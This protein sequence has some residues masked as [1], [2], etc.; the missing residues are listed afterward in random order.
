MSVCLLSVCPSFLSSLTYSIFTRASLLHCL[1]RTGILAVVIS[2]LFVYVLFGSPRE[3]PADDALL[4]AEVAIECLRARQ[5]VLIN[6]LKEGIKSGETIFNS[7]YFKL[8]YT[9]K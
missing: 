5:P 8:Q 1:R 2:P 9:G 4:T 7:K 3:S 6:T